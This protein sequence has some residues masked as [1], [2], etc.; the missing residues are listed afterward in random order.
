[1]DDDCG[2]YRAWFANVRQF[3][4]FT[5]RHVGLLAETKCKALL[6]LART[7]KADAQALHHVLAN[8]DWS[9]EALRT[10]RLEVLRT[11]LAGRKPIFLPLANAGA[12]PE[13]EAGAQYHFVCVEAIN[14]QGYPTSDGDNRA[15]A[16]DKLVTYTL[17]ELRAARPCGMIVCE[18]KGGVWKMDLT[19]VGSGD[20][21]F[22]RGHHFP[23]SYRVLL[24]EEP[25]LEGAPRAAACGSATAGHALARS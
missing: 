13:D 14:P 9:A 1:M 23:T 16:S 3:E 18:L 19:G 4:Q 24:A 25:D 11:A 6:R 8:A 15:A 21:A 2:Q 5:A 17:G 7:A 22:I 20:R 12:L 10:K